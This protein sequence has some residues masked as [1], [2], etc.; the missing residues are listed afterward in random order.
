MFELADVLVGIY[1]THNC[2]KSVTVT[3]RLYAKQEV[4]QIVFVTDNTMG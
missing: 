4:R 2:T 3:P 1:K